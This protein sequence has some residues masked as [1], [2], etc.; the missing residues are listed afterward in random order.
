MGSIALLGSEEQ[1]A[2]W[3]PAMAALDMIG[4]FALTEPGHGSDAVAPRDQRPARAKRRR[5]RSARQEVG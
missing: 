2:R 4:A 5:A 1:K 3:L